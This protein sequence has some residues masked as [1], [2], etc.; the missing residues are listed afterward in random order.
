VSDTAG[1]GP[2]PL[3]VLTGGGYRRQVLIAISALLAPAGVIILVVFVATNRSP[4]RATTAPESA[5]SAAPTTGPDVALPVAIPAVGTSIEVGKTPV[6]VAVSPNGRHV[7][8][9]NRDTQI[10]TVVDTVINQV[11]ATVPI[12]AGPPQFVA[13]APDGRTLYVSIFNDQQTIPVGKNPRDIS[14]APEGRF[15]YVV[16]EGSKTVSVI[17]TV[18]SSASPSSRAASSISLHCIYASPRPMLARIRVVTLEVPSRP[19]ATAP[20]LLPWEL[21]GLFSRSSKNV[22]QPPLR[23]LWRTSRVA[24]DSRCA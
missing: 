18:I 10:L 3:D 2:S 8:I 22:D 19:T 12:N 16:N 4:S 23:S 15:A 13:F 7:Y 21:G 5:R 20:A 17:D 14:W 24:V 6:F 9:A 11:T 1:P